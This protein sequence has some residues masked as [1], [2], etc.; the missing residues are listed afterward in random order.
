[1]TEKKLELTRRR[2]LGSLLA[3]GAGTAAA[4]AGTFAAFS[5]TE[6]SSSNTLTAGTLD[7]ELT[8]GDSV[9]TPITF[10]NV[11]PGD[12]GY[13][14]VGLENTGSVSGDV[15]NVALSITDE[16]DGTDSEFEDNGDEAVLADNVE[17]GV[18]FDGS[19]TA[20]TDTGS[21][22]SSSGT[23]TVVDDGTVL[24]SATGDQTPDSTVSLGENGSTTLVVNWE[25][26]TTAGNDIQG[27]SVTF[28]ITVDLT[29]PTE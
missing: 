14:A 19:V 21:Q 10:S 28:D 17:V 11:K 6:T 13:V 22:P 3:I 15:T 18:F 29:Q 1:M 16:E 5:D 27:D 8:A 2:A 26:P 7:L 9:S 12:T 24:S 23:N 20:G 4:G 25:V